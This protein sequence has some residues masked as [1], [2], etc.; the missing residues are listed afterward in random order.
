MSSIAETG[1]SL[2]WGHGAS[3]ISPLGRFEATWDGDTLT[4]RPLDI[5]AQRF[6]EHYKTQSEKAWLDETSRLLQNPR[7]SP[8]GSDPS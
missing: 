5:T 7:R 6:V 1:L 4:L 2:R 3:P 8:T